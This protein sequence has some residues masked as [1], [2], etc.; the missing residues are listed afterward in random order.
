MYGVT[1]EPTK[2]ANPGEKQH[3]DLVRGYLHMGEGGH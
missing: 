1:V 3:I 2:W